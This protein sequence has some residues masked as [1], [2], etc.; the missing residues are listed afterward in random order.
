MENLAIV[1]SEINAEVIP[2]PSRKQKKDGT[3]KNTP[4]N[5]KEERWVDPIREKH[6]I[7]KV[8]LYLLNKAILMEK[9]DSKM[10]AYRNWL[11]FVIGI[12]VGLRVSDLIELKWSHFFEE[13]M[14]TFVEKINKKEKKT[15]KM[16][17]ICPNICIVKAVN[18]YLSALDLHPEYDDYV[19]I[20]SRT[21]KRI[22]DATVEKFI[23]EF[24]KECNLKG[25]Y[26]THSLRKTYA[27]QKYMNYVQ[28]DDSLAL[29]KVQK[30][31]NH[32]NSSDTAT[33]LGITREER[34]NSSIDLG[35]YLVDAIAF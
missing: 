25:N 29:V 24:A 7:E 8:S 2:F 3:F 27:Y 26:G 10:A 13:D 30:E 35:V 14:K 32:R 22:S 5:N 33:Y 31:L 19:F 18:R 9:K 12:N 34:I 15:G 23:K 21:G 6:D 11:T 28:Q 1:K 17:A 20:N 4:N 16:K